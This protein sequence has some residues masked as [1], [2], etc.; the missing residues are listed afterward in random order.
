MSDYSEQIEHEQ[1]VISKFEKLGNTI[2][3]NFTFMIIFIGVGI[4]IGLSI[5]KELYVNKMNEAIKLGGL[6]HKNIVYDI[7]LRP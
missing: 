3:K 5:S 2:K 6:I 1:K 4:A 7:R